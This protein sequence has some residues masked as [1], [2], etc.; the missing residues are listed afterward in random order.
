VSGDGDILAVDLQI[1]GN[2]PLRA[3]AGNAEEVEFYVL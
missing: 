1:G 2:F 3:K